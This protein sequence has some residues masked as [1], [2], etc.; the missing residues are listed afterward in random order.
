M[1]QKVGSS[2]LLARPKKFKV[3]LLE[4]LFILLML[5]ILNRDD[6]VSQSMESL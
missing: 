2:I 4:V 1:V 5:A 3:L 6:K